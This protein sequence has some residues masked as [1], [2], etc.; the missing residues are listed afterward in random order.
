LERVQAEGSRFAGTEEPVWILVAA[1]GWET[2]V[3]WCLAGAMSSA[4]ERCPSPAWTHRRYDGPT[5]A[6]QGF[7]RP[8]FLV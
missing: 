7:R 6:E 3:V 5:V 8:C 4:D 1:V 2:F